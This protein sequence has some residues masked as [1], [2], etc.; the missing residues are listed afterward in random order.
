[1]INVQMTDP[2]LEGIYQKEYNSDPQKF[3]NKVKTLFMEEKEQQI[4]SLLKRYENADISVG[5]IAEE[6]HIDRDEV[7]ALMSK[8]NVYL[9]DD[10]YDLSADEET[11]KKYLAN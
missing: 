11:M 9:L 2:W 1:M 4:V 8:Y 5:K 10:D 6:L 3:F 7:L